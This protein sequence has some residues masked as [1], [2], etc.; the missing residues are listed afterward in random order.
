MI[1]S[2]QKTVAI[3]G[4]PNV[5][6][7]SLFNR[8]IGKREA[9]ETPIPG[10]TRDRLFGEVS[11]RGVTFDL[12]DVA[13]IEF[14]LKAELDKNTQEGVNSAI[15]NA[16]LILFLVDWNEKN[17]D[18]DRRIA[19]TLRTIKKPV[20]LIVNKCDNLERIESTDEFKRLGNFPVVPV[21]AISGKSSGDLLD[22]IVEKLKVKRIKIEKTENNKSDGEI[23][24]A[25][26]GRPNVGKSTLI[27]TILGEKRVVVSEVPGTTRDTISINFM[28]KGHNIELAD[29]AGLRRPGKIVKDTIES[30]ASLRT[31]RA[32]KECDVAVLLID[33]EEGLVATDT[34]ILGQAKEWGKGLVLAVNKID[35][36]ADDAAFAKGEAGAPAPQK[37][38]L[39]GASDEIGMRGKIDE[40]MAQLLFYLQ[41]KLNFTPWLPTVFI[42]AKDDQNIKPL[43]NQVI[44]SFENRKTWIPEEE[45]NSI[46]KEAKENNNQIFNILS[47][48][49]KR[50]SPPTFEAKYCKK[51][52]HETQL[53]YLENKIRDIYPLPGSPMF[54]DLISG[55]NV[56]K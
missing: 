4:R 17:N 34:H 41:K 33:A 5:G 53:R 47:L 22:I 28:H 55:K 15:E 46:L 29:T 27:N 7:S 50:T 32:L 20:L 26:I 56:R 48:K 37:G 13:G 54:L 30:F 38:P 42:S 6:K 52:P 21:S 35:V 51:A 18:I 36:W 14:G 24:L 10:T 43:L 39:C 8:L 40:K 3:I 11:W 49:Q 45:L 9:I 1:N 44:I 31:N 19:R 23:K 16:D 2:N 25:I 12:V